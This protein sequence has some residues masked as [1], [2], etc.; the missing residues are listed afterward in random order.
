MKPLGPAG[1]RSPQRRRSGGRTARAAAVALALAALA[2]G[3]GVR[4]AV[5][6]PTRGQ[7]ALMSLLVPGLGQYRLG[8]HRMATVFGGVEVGGWAAYVTFR[9]EVN[10]R[11]DSQVLYAKIH[12]RV[13]V[14][15]QGDTY[16]RDV[17]SF[18]SSDEYN[19]SVALFNA[20]ALYGGEPDP[21][22]RVRLI[23]DYVQ[24]HSYTGSQAW[25]WDSN[26]S[27]IDYLKLLKS[28]LS[29]NR[30]G[31]FALGVLVANHL[32][33]AADALRPRHAAGEKL[34]LWDAVPA[35]TL[36]GDGTPALVWSAGF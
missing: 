1:R 14:S 3:A 18:I 30:N 15:G 5:A 19:R 9:H 24:Q 17:G 8:D 13:D 20:E 27:R 29:A 31:N 32:L 25:R 4:P 21:A 16:E 23:Q 35:L 10:L 22:Q 6:D 33:A 12:A 28:G 36:R 26:D 34:G 11:H 7:A 2:A